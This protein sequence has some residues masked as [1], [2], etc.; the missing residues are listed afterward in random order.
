MI[1]LISDKLNDDISEET[2]HGWDLAVAA[3]LWPNPPVHLRHM[4]GRHQVIQQLM[5]E[6]PERFDY[7]RNIAQA[8]FLLDQA[9]GEG[10]STVVIAEC[11]VGHHRSVAAVEIIADFLRG[12]HSVEPKILHRQL[13]APG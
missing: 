12:M 8:A 1:T 3:H 6:T 11:S 7:L 10:T 4:D 9:R 13:E 2:I 5:L